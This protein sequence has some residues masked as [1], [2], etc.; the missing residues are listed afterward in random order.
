MTEAEAEKFVQAFA[1]ARSRGR[2]EELWSDGGELHYPF[3]NRIVGGDEMGMLNDLAAKNSPNVTWELLGWTHRQNVIVVEWRCTNR[4][5]DTRI[6]F[7]GVDKL[8]IVAGKIVKEVVYTDTAPLQAMRQGRTF[9]AL[10]QLP[11]RGE[12]FA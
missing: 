7:S 8:T 4:Y 11:K 5:G 2:G 1:T 9:E 12:R 6:E 3:A 10:I